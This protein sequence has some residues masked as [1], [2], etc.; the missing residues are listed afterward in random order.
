MGL[1]LFAYEPVHKADPFKKITK[2]EPTA[3]KFIKQHKRFP[4][5]YTYTGL[6]HLTSEIVDEALSQGRKKCEVRSRR[7]EIVRLSVCY[8][9]FCLRCYHKC[10]CSSLPL[11][12]KRAGTCA[13]H[14]RKV[15]IL[16]VQII[17][18]R[19]RTVTL[20]RALS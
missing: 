10:L 20:V 16:Q 3:A 15:T 6:G 11:R 18:V 2:I 17:P 19:Q 5:P 1:E 9:G 7:S 4:H 14:D 13:Y 8:K 12:R